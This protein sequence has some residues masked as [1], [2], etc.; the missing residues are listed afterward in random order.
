MTGL[1]AHTIAGMRPGQLLAIAYAG[2][3]V[4]AVAS[5]HGAALE[6]TLGAD[7]ARQL[8]QDLIAASIGAQEQ[9]LA[10]AT[11]RPTPGDVQDMRLALQQ[12]GGADEQG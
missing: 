7:N 4:L 8:G 12:L 11:G 1:P 5:G 3:V 2:R 9:Q 6:V 10:V